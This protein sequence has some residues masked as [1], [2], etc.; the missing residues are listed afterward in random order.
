MSAYNADTDYAD[1][2]SGLGPPAPSAPPRKSQS[3]SPLLSFLDARTQL[4]F[5]EP[6]DGE[7][8]GG[9][10]NQVDVATA[11]SFTWSTTDI[12]TLA[13]QTGMPNLNEMLDG[14]DIIY[15]PSEQLLCLGFDGSAQTKFC[16]QTTCDTSSHR[17]KRKRSEQFRAG[18]Y[19]K[20]A[21]NTV[22]A[23]PCL[24]ADKVPLHLLNGWLDEHNNKVGIWCKQ[25]VL[26]LAL[27]S[28]PTAIGGPDNSIDDD[29][30][31]HAKQVRTPI[32]NNCSK[33]NFHNLE[34]GGLSGSKCPVIEIN[35]DIAL[36]QPIKWRCTKEERDSWTADHSLPQ[37]LVD[38]LGG[39]KE[40]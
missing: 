27:D 14:K 38:L 22:C 11:P 21:A 36:V 39:I 16:T 24:S 34:K 10:Y 3:L 32:K 9:I 25:F 31:K 28:K 18:L 17:G 13:P 23:S 20:A 40:L 19:I 2:L 29:F 30:I 8:G 5:T 15:F 4:S 33:N 37:T 1:L 6:G 35:D 7:V 12:T 26:Y